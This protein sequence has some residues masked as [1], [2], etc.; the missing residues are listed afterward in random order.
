[1]SLIYSSLTQNIHLSFISSH[2]SFTECVRHSDIPLVS[3]QVSIPNI[4]CAE[5]PVENQN[6]IKYKCDSG[7][8]THSFTNCSW[9][10]T[11][12][13]SDGGAIHL[14]F[15][16]PHSSIS[17]CVSQCTFLHCHETGS[18]DGGAVYARSIG[19]TS[20]SNSFFYDCECGS[21]INNGGA[22]ICFDAISKHP[23]IIR[24]TFISCTTADDGGGCEIWYSKADSV[25]A[26]DS[27]VCIRCKG[28]HVSDS[29]GGW[30]M[31]S[32][33][34]DPI[35]CTNSLLTACE[36]KKQ[37]GGIWINYPADKFV[38]PVIFCFFHEN[39]SPS[40]KD[41]CFYEYRSDIQPILY[42][43]ISDCCDK[44]VGGGSNNWLP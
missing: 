32:H 18:V 29:Q 11:G 21:Y 35:T 12:L 15:S 4:A 27:C 40:G 2:S 17:L 23:S 10:N 41:V 7:S 38:K 30:I 3:L 24:C 1:M 37:G 33:N 28:T 20:V 39:K 36:T 34:T 13:S 8:G 14:I 43:F 25:Y 22:G 16:E 5:F 9:D 44:R 31:I 19:T 42:S 6:F 26:I